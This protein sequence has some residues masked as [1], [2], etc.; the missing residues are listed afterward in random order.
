MKDGMREDDVDV[1][2]EIPSWVLKDVFNR[3]Q[4]RKA[5][6]SGNCRPCKTH[7]RHSCIVIRSENPVRIL[8]DREQN[9]R[10]YCN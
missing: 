10:A 4:K 1:N 5:D 8:G 3:S 9:L 6:N 7:C 2:V